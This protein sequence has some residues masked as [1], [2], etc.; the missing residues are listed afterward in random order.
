MVNNIST[1][2][3]NVTHNSSLLNSVTM[4]LFSSL[5]YKIQWR[6]SHKH[7][8]QQQAITRCSWLQSLMC[9]VSTHRLVSDVVNGADQHCI[10]S[11]NRSHIARWEVLVDPGGGGLPQQRH[12]PRQIIFTGSGWSLGFTG[13]LRRCWQIWNT[14]NKIFYQILWMQLITLFKIN[15]IFNIDFTFI[16]CVFWRHMLSSTIDTRTAE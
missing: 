7:F 11:M 12:L 14:D 9:E 13:L 4:K 3:Y 15:V 6:L 10:L 2:I 16:N 1:I 8:Q 5:F